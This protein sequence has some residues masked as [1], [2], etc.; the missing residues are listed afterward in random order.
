[1]P[2]RSLIVSIHDISPF[3]LHAVQRQVN[4]MTRLGAARL[5]L[6]VI[7]CHRDVGRLDQHPALVGWLRRWQDEGHEIV[8]HGWCHALPK[9]PAK[10]PFQGGLRRWFYEELYTAREAEFFALDRETAFPLVQ[11]G[12]SDLATHGLR[13]KGFVAPAW[14]LNP[15]VEEALRAAELLYTTTRTEIVH[16]PSGTRIPAPSCVWST[17]T[18]WR[19]GASLA[20]NALLARRLRKAEPM[21]IGIHPTDLNSPAVWKQILRTVAAALESRRP[22]PYG[23]WVSARFA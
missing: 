4:E 13:A 11:Q 18:P 1:M 10:R 20:W 7:P 19:R 21:R 9:E 15:Q 16:L 8:L 12:L 14:L 17:R 6:L 5:S 3:H 23:N 22:E 2:P